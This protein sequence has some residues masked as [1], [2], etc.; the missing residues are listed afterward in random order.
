MNFFLILFISLVSAASCFSQTW[1]DNSCPIEV[2]ISNEQYTSAKSNNLLTL[3]IDQ[4]GK[5][6][7]DGKRKD[8]ISEIQFKETV[9]DFLTNPSKDKNK[10]DSPKQAIIAL[11]SYGKHDS[12]DLILRYVREVYLYAWDTASEEKYET[13]YMDLDCKMRK[14]IRDKSFPYHILELDSKKK[15]QK[16]PNSTPGVPPFASD[17]IDY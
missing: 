1:L 17:I 6:L 12:Y 10:A 14:K 11:G 5:L 3:I 8:G 13:I 2:E 4:E 16:K 9:Y 7:M 15:E